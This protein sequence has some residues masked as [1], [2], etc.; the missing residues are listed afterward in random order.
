MKIHVAGMTGIF[1]YWI[2]NRSLIIYGFDLTCPCPLLLLRN[3]LLYKRD[4]VTYI[5]V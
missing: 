5:S 1:I 4:L 3:K 2:I